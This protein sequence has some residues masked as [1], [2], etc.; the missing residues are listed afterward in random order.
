[1]PLIMPTID[2]LDK[3]DLNLADLNSNDLDL[4]QDLANRE[5]PALIWGPGQQIQNNT[6]S[7]HRTQS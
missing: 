2:N 4:N 7:S 5:V 3:S 6:E 1:M